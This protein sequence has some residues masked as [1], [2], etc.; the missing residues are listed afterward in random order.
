M[1]WWFVS[2]FFFEFNEIF[3]LLYKIHNIFTNF[4]FFLF[5]MNKK[6]IDSSPKINRKGRKEKTKK[7]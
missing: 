6:K 3:F 4:W 2:F 7:K 1:T 5:Q